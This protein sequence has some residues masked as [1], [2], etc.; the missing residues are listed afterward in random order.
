[1]EKFI[2]LRKTMRSD[3]F[4]LHGVATAEKRSELSRDAQTSRRA[5]DLIRLGLR[6]LMIGRRSANQ[7]GFGRFGH[8]GCYVVQTPDNRQAEQ[9]R[10]LLADD[11]LIVPDVQLSLPV[12]RAGETTTAH[13]PRKSQWPDVSGI[14]QAHKAGITGKNIIVGI[15]DT[16]CDAD[17]TE[18]KRKRI[19][20]RYVPLMS[21]PENLRAVRGFDTHGHGTHVSGVVAGKNIGVAPDAELLVAAVIESETIK[22]SLERIVV[23]LDWM[24]A[25]FSMPENQQKPMIISMS[26]GF[27]PEWISAPDFK[28]VTDGMQLLL[29]TLVEDFD[30]LPVVAIGNDGPGVIR[31]PGYFSEAL[32]VGAVDF[33]L[34]P[35][36]N[37][38][39][40]VSPENLNKPDIA[41]F[42]VDVMSSLERTIERRSLYTRMS[43]TSMA[44]PYVAGIA[45]LTA[46]ANPG[47]QGETLRQRLLE[48]AWTL[49]APSERV[50]AGLARFVP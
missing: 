24:L 18:L 11:Y 49:A 19:E 13:R 3:M 33:D 9:A 23:A 35:W 37:S 47:L 40:G 21:A 48:T 12:A 7:H 36:P 10:E 39:S 2:A 26:L 34:N 43:G 4:D 16:G 50:G 32:A 28:T 17:H 6:P 5:L 29:R 31:A 20:F 30:V 8:V 15:L 44:T 14:A 25:H 45:A 38:S 41:G 1:M 46:Q 22:T 42:G 27:R